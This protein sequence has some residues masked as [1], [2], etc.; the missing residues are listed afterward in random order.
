[1]QR[2]SG[3]AS[4]GLSWLSPPEG[5]WEAAVGRY[6]ASFTA[7]GIQPQD[8]LLRLAWKIGGSAS[9]L[10]SA[11][12]PALA[13]RDPLPDPLDRPRLLLAIAPLPLSLFGTVSPGVVD[14]APDLARALPGC[15]TRVVSLFPAFC[16]PSVVPGAVISCPSCP[17]LLRSL[18][19]AGSDPL[20]AGTA[21]PEREGARNPLQAH[22]EPRGSIVLDVPP[23]RHQGLPSVLGRGA[24]CR[25]AGLLAEAGYPAIGS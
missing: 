22:F 14:A 3:P 5:I 20:G 1:M 2:C 9:R 8:I 24:Q 4:G 25:A 19:S 23:T 11:A 17:L 21:S 12:L 6:R 7:F 18:S 16:W 13:A 15:S 10:V